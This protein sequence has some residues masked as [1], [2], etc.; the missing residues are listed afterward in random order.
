MA[1]T[2]ICPPVRRVM[3]NDPTHQDREILTAT[4]A[5]SY[6]SVPIGPTTPGGWFQSPVLLAQVAEKDSSPNTRSTP[7]ISWLISAKFIC[8]REIGVEALSELLSVFDA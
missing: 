7:Y 4:G 5:L 6:A 2:A 3:R 1:R 8:A